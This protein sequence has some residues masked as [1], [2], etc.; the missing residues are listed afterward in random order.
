MNVMDSVKRGM[1]SVKNDT[2]WTRQSQ[3]VPVVLGYLAHRKQ[4]RILFFIDT[5]TILRLPSGSPIRD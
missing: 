1:D 2:N 4:L 3:S 5:T